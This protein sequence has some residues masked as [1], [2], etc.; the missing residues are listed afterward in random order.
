MGVFA[1]LSDFIT[2]VDTVVAAFAGDETDSPLANSPRPAAAP[3][4][5]EL[6]TGT[7]DVSD[8]VQLREP[9]AATAT[10]GA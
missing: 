4:D 10:T 2:G 1:F 7:L 9:R 3:S 6:A 5:D 8:D